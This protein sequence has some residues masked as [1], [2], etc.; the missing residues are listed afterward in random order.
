MRSYGWWLAG[1]VF[2]G[3]AGRVW[4]AELHLRAIY[5]N[6]PGNDTGEWLAVENNGTAS[7]AAG[8]ASLR[9]K[10]GSTKTYLLPA[11]SAQEL[12]IITAS[13]SGITLNNTREAVELL[14]QNVVIDASPEF[15]ASQEG[16]VFIQLNEGWREISLAEYLERQLNRNWSTVA[17]TED[18]DSTEPDTT[19]ATVSA[20]FTPL[21]WATLIAPA[22]DRAAK[23]VELS[24]DLPTQ[25]S[26]A[27][28]PYRVPHLFTGSPARASP[29]GE[30]N[31]PLP[32]EP[33]YDAEMQVF[34][35]WKRRALFGSLALV[36]GGLCWLLLV[37][38]PPPVLWHWLRDELLL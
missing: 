30:L 31:W 4:A 7:V 19:T 34:L 21:P 3:L 16:M 6:P 5:P 13:E 22:P 10:F 23:Q 8:L 17:V 2:F 25:A 26:P 33:D 37:I 11:L 24:S 29:A 27:P 1:L 14:K 35:D 36:W 9:D 28:L 38:P 12:K 15:V 18:D 32:P 20:T